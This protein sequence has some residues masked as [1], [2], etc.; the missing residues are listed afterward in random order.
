MS[1][2]ADYAASI[3]ANEPFLKVK[4]RGLLMMALMAVMTCQ[5]LDAT[6][7]N[8]A[9]SHMQTS[10]GASS[11]TISWVLTSFIIAGAIFTPITG[12]LA[13]KVGSRRLFLL[14]TFGFMAASA[15]CGAATSLGQMVAF[16]AIQGVAG[17]FL[18]PISQTV[19]YDVTPPSE[20]SKMMGIWGV[21]VMVAPIS[22]PFLGGFLTEEMSWRWVYYVNLPIGVPALVILWFL[23]PSRPI[24]QRKL[25]KF[26]Y[27]AIAIGLGTLQ[28]LLDRGQGRDWLESR[29]II[30]ELVVVFCAF[31]L[32]FTHTIFTSHPLFQPKLFKNANFIAGFLFM[33]VM[34]VTNIAL[35]AALPGLFQNVFHYS[36]LQSGLMMAPRGLGVLS[37]MYFTNLIMKHVDFRYMICFGYLIAAYSMHTMTYWTLE[38]DAAPM[39]IS[40]FIQ[41]IGLGFVF[42][43]MNL[44]AFSTL[45]PQLRTDGASLL[46]LSRNLGGSF[47]ISFMVTMLSRLIQTNHAEIGAHVTASVVNGVDLPN[48]IDRMQGYGGAIMMMVDGQVNR[49]AVMIAYLDNFRAITWLLLIVA[50]LPFLLK[51]Q[52]LG[53]PS[54]DII[55]E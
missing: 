37:M 1:G 10:L 38:T 27:I 50:P 26:G 33:M 9:L 14:A 23:M 24:I 41:G 25:D 42:M 11:D 13:D 7:Q 45:E 49:Q 2:S 55:M 36:V 51:A 3:A 39:I 20:Q 35:G 52:K 29:E 30:F 46:A 34:G 47:G 16:R 8:V 22:G 17:A 5:V 44:I 18:L 15:L 43:P 53:Q 21:V 19:I 32:F 28:L 48:T 12:W 40:G 4:H 31:W 6:I 54:Q